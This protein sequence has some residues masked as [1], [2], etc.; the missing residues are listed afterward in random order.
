MYN[1]YYYK[2]RDLNNHVFTFYNNIKGV[3]W[4]KTELEMADSFFEGEI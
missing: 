4:E 1:D 2:T 3:Q